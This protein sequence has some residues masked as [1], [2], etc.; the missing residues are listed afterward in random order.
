MQSLI[1]RLKVDKAPP[2][3]KV[4][5]DQEGGKAFPLAYFVLVSHIALTTFP[6]LLVHPVATETAKLATLAHSYRSWDRHF[7]VAAMGAQQ[8]LKSLYL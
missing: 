8:A 7:D 1:G 3:R 2:V 4:E 5:G 6:G